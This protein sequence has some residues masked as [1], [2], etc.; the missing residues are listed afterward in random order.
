MKKP[1]EVISLILLPFCFAVGL[2]LLKE[3]VSSSN[4]PAVS[5]GHHD[6][7]PF[8]QI[9]NLL[10]IGL[11]ALSL[12]LPAFAASRNEPIERTEIKLKDI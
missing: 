2:M 3:K 12:I 11:F 9:F 10:I 6:D 4:E 7:S 5:F 8:E 1:V